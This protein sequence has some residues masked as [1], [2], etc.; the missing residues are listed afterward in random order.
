MD[1]IENSSS[2]TPDLAFLKEML[3][4]DKETLKEVLQIFLEEGPILLNQLQRAAQEK[5]HD[6]LNKITHKMIAELTTVGVTSVVYDLKRINKSSRE[7]VDLDKVIERVT[8][9]IND[10]FEYFKT[11]V[12]DI[13]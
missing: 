7:M 13:S 2:P 8:K 9:V 11:I 1:S 6:S 10:S 12:L 4:E 3:G 5:D